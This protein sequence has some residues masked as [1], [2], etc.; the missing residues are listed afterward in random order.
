MTP[1]LDF[2][3][4]RPRRLLEWREED[5]YCV[6]LRPRLGSNRLA[7]WVAGLG[8]DPSYRIRLDEVGTLVGKACDGCTSLADIVSRMRAH[9]GDGVEPADQRLAAFVRKMLKGRMLAVDRGEYTEGTGDRRQ[10]TGEAAGLR[11]S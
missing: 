4:V 5:G 1:G 11:R 6:L 3:G 8:G 9:F 2:A 10:E 7:R